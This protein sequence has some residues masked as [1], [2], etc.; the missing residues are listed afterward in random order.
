MGWV[1]AVGIAS[2][3]VSASGVGRG[4]PGSVLDYFQ[5]H[6]EVEENGYE[7][8]AEAMRVETLLLV[9][10]VGLSGQFVGKAPE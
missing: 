6:S 5:G 3:V 8:V 9:D 7:A 10:D 1:F 2:P 4:V